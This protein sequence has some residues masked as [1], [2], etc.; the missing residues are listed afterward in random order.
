MFWERT[1][2]IQ[3]YI[4]I[5]NSYN[6]EEYSIEEKTNAYRAICAFMTKNDIPFPSMTFTGKNESTGLSKAISV[7]YVFIDPS[8][9]HLEY[10]AYVSA[11]V[12][13]AFKDDRG[14]SEWTYTEDT[15]YREDADA[16]IGNIFIPYDGSE[17]L[18]KEL[19]KLSGERKDDDSFSMISNSLMRSLDSVNGFIE[20]MSTVFMWL[21][22]VLA[23][24]S[25]LLMFNF[26]SVSISAKKKEIGIL[27]AIGSRTWDVFKIFLSEAAIIALICF[28]VA[29][30]GSVG[31]C[32]VL[33]G[34]LMEESAMFSTGL[35]VFGPI[36]VL[37][38]A[39]IALL[40]AVIATVIPV[41][42]YSR[43]PPIASIR[44]L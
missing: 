3:E 14:N 10:C 16:F 25:F 19:I 35:L 4:G 30:A 21:G 29:T 1:T 40:T 41:A 44:A 33:N 43:K 27:R 38:I 32:Y 42:T 7:A 23:A 12:L 31:L 6:G 2:S 8:Q 24:F 9:R 22:I 37:I 36:S 34:I 18:T 5:V 15:K 39:G 13:E 11:D 28:V 17:A 26:I 20:N